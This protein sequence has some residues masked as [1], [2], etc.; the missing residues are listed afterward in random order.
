MSLTPIKKLFSR[1]RSASLGEADK[2]KEEVKEQWYTPD[3][4][5]IEAYGQFLSP[6][7]GGGEKEERRGGTPDH[8]TSTREPLPSSLRRISLR[9]SVLTEQLH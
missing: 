2:D 6:S 5:E 7:R 1:S 3:R 8:S 9:V 4:S